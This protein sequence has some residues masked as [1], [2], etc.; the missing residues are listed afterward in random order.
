V[1][2]RSESGGTLDTADVNGLTVFARGGGPPLLL[3]PYPHAVSVVGNPTMD[4]LIDRLASVGRRVVTFDPPGSGR[5]TRPMRL[6]MSEM[7]DCAEEA[8]AALGISGPVDVFGHSQG[9]V[10]ALAFALERPERVRRMVLANTSSGGPAFL[11]APGAIWNRSHPDFWRFA[12]L[13]VVHLVW[14]RRAAET[15][16]NNL[17]FRDSYVDRKRFTPTPITFVDW[18]RP[19]RTRDAW[20]LRVAWRLDY[21]KRLAEV[22]AATLVTAG[23]FDPQIPLACAC[24]LADGIRDARLVVFERSGHYPFVEEPEE[25]WTNVSKF[26]RTEEHLESGELERAQPRAG[27]LAETW[28][29]GSSSEAE[30][31]RV[32]LAERTSR[33]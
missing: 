17:I 2:T 15:L 4:L 22:R 21:G 33:L 9:G 14:R 24:E 20:G 32:P 30:Q 29:R 16:M 23:R 13:G 31:T 11:R 18:F 7:L 26:V 19:A 28:A 27:E 6:G 3:M 10:A 1:S 8:L 25:F 12:L 5:S